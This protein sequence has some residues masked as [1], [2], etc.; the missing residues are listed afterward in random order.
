MSMMPWVVA[1]SLWQI[2]KGNSSF[3]M[4]KWWNSGIIHNIFRHLPTADF[5]FKTVDVYFNKDLFEEHVIGDVGDLQNMWS[6][7][8]DL[9]VDPRGQE[10]NLI[11]TPSPDGNF[12]IKDTWNLI[13][14]KRVVVPSRKWI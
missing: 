13:N 11:W 14:S 6:A 3:W 10:D 7:L 5:F 1:N 9:L 2:D 4:D 8:Q 12:S